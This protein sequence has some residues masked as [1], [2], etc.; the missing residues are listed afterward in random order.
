MVEQVDF[1]NVRLV[2]INLT[3]NIAFT[4]SAGDKLLILAAEIQN[5]NGFLLHEGSPFSICSPIELL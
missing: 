2:R 4:Y 1:G 5:D 3:I